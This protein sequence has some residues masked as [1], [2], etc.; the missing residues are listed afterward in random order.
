M[1]QYPDRINKIKQDLVFQKRNH[2]TKYQ[3]KI[4][5][6]GGLFFQ[7]RPETEKGNKNPKNPVNPV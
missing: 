1:S 5:A 3:E 6:E 2:V 4:S 7:F